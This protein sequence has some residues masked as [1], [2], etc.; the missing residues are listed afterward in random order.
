MSPLSRRQPPGVDGT[1]LHRAGRFLGGRLLSRQGEDEL[2][3][4]ADQGPA[5]GVIVR[6]GLAHHGKGPHHLGLVVPQGDGKGRVGVEFQAGQPRPRFLPE[7]QR[8]LVPCGPLAHLCSLTEDDL[9]SFSLDLRGGLAAQPEPQQ[10]R[11]CFQ[12]RLQRAVPVGRQPFCEFPIDGSGAALDPF[13]HFSGFPAKPVPAVQ[14]LSLRNHQHRRRI[15]DVAVHHVLGG[16][17]EEGRQGVEIPLGDGIELVVVAGGASHGEAEKDQ[18]GGIGPVLGV[19]GL[20]LFGNDAALVGGDVASMKAGGHQPVQVGFRQHVARDLFDRELVEGLVPV[21]GPDHPVAV[22]PHLPIVVDVDAVGVSVAGRVQ[23]V[24]GTVLAPVLR[25]HEAVDQGFVGAVGIVGQEGGQGS[26]VGRQSR[27]IQGQS[28]G[29]G[30]LVGFGSRRQTL[31][32][33]TGQ[34]EAVQRVADPGGVFHRRRFRPADGLEGPV[35]VPGG[36][37]CDPLAESGDLLGVQRPLGVGGRHPQG[38]LGMGDAL[39]EQAGLGIAWDDQASAGPLREGSLPGIE[40]EIHHPGGRIGPVALETVVGEDGTN[41]PLEVDGAC[42]RG[43][44]LGR[45]TAH[46]QQQHRRHDPNGTR[47]DLH[48]LAS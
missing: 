21:E 39:V 27:Q 41:V 30:V 17:P 42:A 32:F 2:P 12:R 16:V 40:P 6:V 8:A 18:P 28:A 33:Q 26:R 5:A 15:G 38:R 23:P 35:P 47:D 36:S 44:L 9:L 22:G 4:A 43:R 14:V 46:P 24:A 31:G 29:Q 7:P 48:R 34:D 1:D 20:V 11:R 19:D 13:F 45:R 10:L 3:R 25:L 37:L